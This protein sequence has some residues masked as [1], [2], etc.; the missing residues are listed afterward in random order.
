MLKITA[1]DGIQQ[2]GDSQEV[3]CEV[4]SLTGRKLQTFTARKSDITQRLSTQL[5]SSTY[6]VKM[7]A[8]HQTEVRKVTIRK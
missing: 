1:T 7:R 5:R 3:V 8:D 6:L 2:I 4:Y